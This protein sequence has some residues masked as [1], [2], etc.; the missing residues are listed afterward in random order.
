MVCRLQRSRR[1]NAAESAV[2]IAGRWTQL[3]QVTAAHEL[4][5]SI[6]PLERRA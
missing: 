4:R 3:R 1:A 5:S 6:C 2:L